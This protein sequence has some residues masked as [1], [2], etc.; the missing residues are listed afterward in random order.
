MK[1]IRVRFTIGPLDER[2]DLLRQHLS[3]LPDKRLQTKFILE[4]LIFR[5]IED[6]PKNEVDTTTYSVDVIVNEYSPGLS[7][8]FNALSQLQDHP[9]RVVWLR[10]ML[11]N[12]CTAT[13]APA[14]EA[15][16][17][18]ITAP[19]ADDSK[20]SVPVAPV[21]SNVNSLPPKLAAQVKRS[22]DQF[23]SM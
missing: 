2:L 9:S 23:N 15:Q 1:S 17:I 13:N 18:Q 10:R 20:A 19:N 5:R 22:L 12:I 16:K 11:I 8:V 21:A 3:E 7:D 6:P 14:I 4:K